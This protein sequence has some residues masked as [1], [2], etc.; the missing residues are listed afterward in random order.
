MK[1]KPQPTPVPAT[2]QDVAP[3]DANPPYEAPAVIYDAPLE[4]RAGTPLGIP[5]PEDLMD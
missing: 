5:A 4:V 1:P 3:A 2:A